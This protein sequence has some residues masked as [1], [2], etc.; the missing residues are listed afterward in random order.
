M[1]L[2]SF[3]VDGRSRFGAVIDNDIIDLAARAPECASLRELIT[4]HSL[5]EIEQLLVGAARYPLADVLL[6]PPITDAEKI[7]CVGLNYHDHRN[8]V[9]RAVQAHPT[10]FTRFNDSHVGHLATVPFTV[11]T[12]SLDYEGE[13]A[14][15]VGAPLWQ[16]TAEEAA[17][18]IFGYSVYND[19]SIREWQKHSSQWTPG[20]NK[21][22]TGSFGPYLVTTDEVGD[23]R[24]ARL[25][26]RVDGVVVQ[27]AV[28]GDLIFGIPELL[29]YITTFTPLN[30]G[31]VVVT[32][33]P[34][35][36]GMSF[37]PPRYLQP[38]QLVEVEVSGIGLLVNRVGEKTPDRVSVEFNAGAA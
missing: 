25:I 10:L 19:Y 30:P 29:S 32:G 38:G 12:D 14:L 37:D 9:G 24:Q 26:T 4:R 11:G 18:G 5:A 36:V 15:V 27:S 28:I 7:I 1:R 6:L 16:A 31:D 3:E 22:R 21:Y 34:G 13:L 8:E 2:V 17:S 35:G 20:K 33:T 23:V